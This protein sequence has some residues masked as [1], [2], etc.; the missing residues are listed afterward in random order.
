MVTGALPAGL[1]IAVS[2]NTVNITGT[3]LNIG[4]TAIQIQVKDSAGEVQTVVLA[5]DIAPASPK[6][7]QTW[8]VLEAILGVHFVHRPSISCPLAPCIVRLASGNLPAGL[9]LDSAT[10]MISGVPTAVGQSQF[11]LIVEDAMQGQAGAVYAILVRLPAGVQSGATVLPSAIVNFQ[12]H[13]GLDDRLTAPRF[14]WL[15][16]GGTVPPGLT[17]NMGG[18][19]EGIPTRVGTYAFKATVNASSGLETVSREYVLTVTTAEIATIGL[20]NAR[21]GVR[22]SYKLEARNGKTPY[23][24]SLVSGSLPSR[25]ELTEA[26]Q[27]PR[28]CP[29]RSG[30]PRTAGY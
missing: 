17:M 11:G 3:P 2:G 27:I 10:G 13:I 5:V 7:G 21:R 30:P 20:P 15:L 29:T 8:L 25:L 14:Y 6:F 16:A 9:S 12:Y 24:W 19:L 1:Q 26:G 4:A 22:Y 23:T 28:A 18:I